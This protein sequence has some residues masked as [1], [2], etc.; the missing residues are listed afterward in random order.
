MSEDKKKS[1]QQ[2]DAEMD[3]STSPRA[4]KKVWEEP[5][6]EFVEPKLTKHGPVKKLTGGFFGTFSP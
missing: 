6:L 3:N 5:K 1:A 2:I 4:G